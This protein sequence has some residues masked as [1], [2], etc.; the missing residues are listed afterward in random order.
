MLFGLSV[1]LFVLVC[2]FLILLVII[3]SDKGGGLS[4]TI[5]GGLS[6][7]SAFLGTQDTA[8]ILTR[9]TTGF[10]VAYM[11]LCIILSLF[12]SRSSVKIQ[13]SELKK[14]A[15]T[16]AKFS[17]ASALGGGLPLKGEEEGAAGALPLGN[18]QGAGAAKGGQP[19]QQQA[20]PLPAAQKA[21]AALPLPQKKGK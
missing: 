21:P 13:E 9:L 16:Q 18:Q 8:N 6:S 15:E 14:R 12:F 1:V 4:S 20:A 5:G 2:L 17:P 11:V 19:A 7:A 10:A 3:Q